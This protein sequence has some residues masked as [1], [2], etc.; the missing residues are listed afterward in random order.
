MSRFV[1][2]SGD[3]LQIEYVGRINQVFHH[4]DKNLESDLSL[5][6]MASVACFSPFHFHGRIS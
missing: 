4:I 5:A 3:E 1:I 2:R 6:K